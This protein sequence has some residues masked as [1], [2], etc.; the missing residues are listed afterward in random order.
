MLRIKLLVAP[1]GR[2]VEELPYTISYGPPSSVNRDAQ[3][4]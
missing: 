3:T 1:E 2:K 4:L